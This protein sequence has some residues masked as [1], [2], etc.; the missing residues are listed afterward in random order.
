VALFGSFSLLGGDALRMA[1]QIPIRKPGRSALT[2]LGLAIGVGTFIA[3]VSFGR[4]AR[5]SVVSQFETLGTNQLRVRPRLNVVERP[6]RFLGEAD[7]L[8]LKREGTTF[9]AVVPQ[10]SSTYDIEYRGTHMRTPVVGALPELKDTQPWVAE[11]GGLIDATDVAGRAKVCVIGVTPLRKLFGS[12]DA[13][14]QTITIGGK[15]PCRVIGVT[16]E[17]GSSISGGDLDDRVYVPL[18]TYATYL[19]LPQGYSVIEV[20]PQ[21]KA[22]LEPAKTEIRQIMIR[23]HQLREGGEL[24]FTIASPD[25][26]TL[27]AEQ[28]GAALTGL[29]AG[30]AAV[31]LL[32]GGIGIM[33]IQLVSV[34]E[35]THEIGIRAAIGASSQQIMTQFLAEALVLAVL[36]SAAGVALGIA[37]AWVVADLM[38]WPR[39]IGADVVIGSALFGLFVGVLFGYVPA[40]RAADLDPIEA[41]RRE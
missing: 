30:I 13:L 19:G 29:L 23:S 20:R 22:L 10:A 8:A 16:E 24:D 36:G 31:S 9:A 38:R 4:G 5:S 6:P 2:T 41:L 27:V 1:L 26:V 3:M 14:G 15:L 28:I 18:T 40:K 32:V 11:Q 34:A 33:N 17:R 7:V 21:S 25:D 39:E 37:S 35:R 12:A